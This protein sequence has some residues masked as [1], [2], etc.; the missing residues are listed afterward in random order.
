MTLRLESV[1]S[2][3]KRKI[4]ISVQATIV[5]N[6]MLKLCLIGNQ[7]NIEHIAEG[8]TSIDQQILVGMCL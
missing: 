8:I 4:L 5:M 1:F 2:L 6:I 3:L 7:T